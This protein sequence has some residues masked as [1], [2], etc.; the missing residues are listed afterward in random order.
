MNTIVRL[1]TP[2]KRPDINKLIHKMNRTHPL[3][4]LSSPPSFRSLL[5]TD[6]IQYIHSPKSLIVPLLRNNL[7]SSTSSKLHNAVF[8]PSLHPHH[9]F[10]PN[11]SSSYTTSSTYSPQTHGSPPRHPKPAPQTSTVSPQGSTK[12]SSFKA[13][14]YPP[15]NESSTSSSK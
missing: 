11:Q 8:D 14:N 12:L 7:I 1:N 4:P 5:L 3:L 10:Y 15:P 9:S 13:T 6:F 2:C